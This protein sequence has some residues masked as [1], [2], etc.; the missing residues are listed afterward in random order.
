MCLA[1]HLDSEHVYVR[2]IGTLLGAPPPYTCLTKDYILK[3]P[4]ILLEWNYSIQ[5]PHQYSSSLSPLPPTL[6][7]ARFRNVPNIN[8]NSSTLSKAD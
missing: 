7:E 8:G 5:R 4:V 6:L 1:L 3:W 2:H